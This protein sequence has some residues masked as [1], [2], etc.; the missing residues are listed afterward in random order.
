MGTA[1]SQFAAS[2]T[3]ATAADTDLLP[4][5]DVSDT[6]QSP[7]GSTKK[8]TLGETKNYLYGIPVTLAGNTTFA[9][10]THSNRYLL[11]TAAADYT[12]PDDTAEPN[13][14]DNAV[15]YGDNASASPINL[16]GGGSAVLTAETNHSLTVPAGS[17]WSLRRTGA[18]AWRGGALVISAGGSAV[19]GYIAGGSTMYV[20]PLEVNSASWSVIGCAQT[21]IDSSV[22]AGVSALFNTSYGYR[23]IQHT[24]AAVAVNR[25]AGIRGGS[26][27]FAYYPG[28]VRTPNLLFRS[29]FAS[30][31]AL[32][33]CRVFCGLKT[34]GE[35]TATVEP[36][37]FTD[38]VF[39]GADST[40]TNLQV[41]HN[42]SAG[43]CTKVD[44][45]ASF[46]ANSNAV[47]MYEVTLKFNAGASRSVDYTVTNQVSGAQASGTLTTNLPTAGTTVNYAVYR[48]SA[49]N[50]GAAAVIH[51][52]G[53]KSSTYA[54]I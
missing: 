43:A 21:A 35:P 11:G 48:N 54:G 17:S 4:V 39:V 34:G 5:V 8:M 30:C 33:A 36:S 45:G 20:E 32:T 46:P 31:D 28:G 50:A 9:A 18:N 37:T 47:D 19:G 25:G 26:Q 15:L 53:V 27:G 7:N 52:M 29:A 38:V 13:W 49:A 51:I 1:I 10:A 12:V 22:A 23:R 14:A 41:M 16:V 3:A 24:A 6:T 42:D 2:L 44:L 40:D